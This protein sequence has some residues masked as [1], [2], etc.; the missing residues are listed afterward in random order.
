MENNIEQTKKVVFSGIQPSGDLTLGNYLGALKNWVQLQDDYDTFYC[1]VDLHA[2]TVKQEP[3]NLRRRTLELLAIYIAAGIDPEKNTMFIQSH[4]PAHSEAAWLLNC[5]TYVGEL[6]RMTQYK[7][8]SSKYGN[9][10]SA[11]LLNYPVL[12]VADIL[13]Y[14][15]DLVP[16]GKDQKQHLELTR[17]IADRFNKA[18][19]PTFKIPEP[20]IP[21]KG[22]K[23]MDLQEPNKKMSK[24]SDNPNSFILMMDPPDIIRKKIARAVTDSIGEVKYSDEQPGVKNLMTILGALTGASME[25]LEQKYLGQGYAQFKKDVAEA[26]VAELE[27]IQNKV[28]DLLENKTYLEEI[29]KKG[30][31]KANYVAIKT[32]RKMQKKIGL[33]QK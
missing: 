33:I 31:E 13:L 22:T 2:I 18:Y 15:A 16:V 32:L 24:S 8:K 25:Q 26:I 20:Y 7:D 27:P 14:Q 10:I 30:A 3:K 4:V 17:D 12:M 11:G 9:S 28:K 23:I 19:S 21:E 6:S 5:N 1:I 29:Y